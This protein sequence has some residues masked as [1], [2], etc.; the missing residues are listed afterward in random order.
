MIKNINSYSIPNI[1]SAHKTKNLNYYIDKIKNYINL[2]DSKILTDE[3]TQHVIKKIKILENKIEI[4]RSDE[5]NKIKL[6]NNNYNKYI[7][8]TTKNRNSSYKTNKK[9]YIEFVSK[10]IIKYDSSYEDILENDNIPPAFKYICYIYTLMKYNI[11]KYTNDIEELT[12]FVKYFNEEI[13]KM[14]EIHKNE[15]NSYT[16]LFN[17]SLN[18]TKIYDGLFNLF[19]EYD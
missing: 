11:N 19:I 5:C 3:E 2:L 6:N 13:N 12:L 14:S 9:I 10:S 8:E 15:L 7:D 16:D 17:N 18:N 4:I 1:Y